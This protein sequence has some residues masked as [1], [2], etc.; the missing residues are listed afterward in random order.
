MSHCVKHRNFHTIKLGEI[1]VFYAVS[2]T[3]FIYN[4]LRF[5]I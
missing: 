4:T 3:R 1:M 2:D 5:D